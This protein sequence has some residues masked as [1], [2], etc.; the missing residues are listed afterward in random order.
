M[1]EQANIAFPGNEYILVAEQDLVGLLTLIMVKKSLFKFVK[2]V[3]CSVVKLGFKGYLGNKGGVS[4]RFD[5]FDSSVCYINCHLAPHKGETRLRNQH[6]KTLIKQTKFMIAPGKIKNMYE[7]DF[8]IWSGDLN[9]R[10]NRL[11]FGEIVDRIKDQDF[12][13]L[14]RYDQLKVESKKNQILSDFLE[15]DINFP[16][17]YKYEKNSIE[18]LYE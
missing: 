9:Y 4:F 8:I 6:V 5:I 17:T 11:N 16:P 14:L 18:L 10:F 7:H 15:G 13:Y 3:V 1:C 12:K 2:N